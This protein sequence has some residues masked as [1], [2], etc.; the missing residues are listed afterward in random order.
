VSP[1]LPSLQG[2]PSVLATHPALAETPY[3][4]AWGVWEAAPGQTPQLLIVPTQ[5]LAVV[6]GINEPQ[7]AVCLWLISRTLKWLLCQFCP[8]LE[9]L[10]FE[11]RIR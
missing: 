5:S 8:V 9:L 2:K 6:Q 7:T 1:T 3:D 10:S 11:K 4:T